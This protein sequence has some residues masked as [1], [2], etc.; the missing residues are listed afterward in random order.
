MSTFTFTVSPARETQAV[1]QDREFKMVWHQEEV[2]G[3][4]AAVEALRRLLPRLKSFDCI[5]VQL[6]GGAKLMVF[7][8]PWVGTNYVLC[9]KLSVSD[10]S[11]LLSEGERLG[12]RQFGNTASGHGSG[13]IS[14]CSSEQDCG[15]ARKC[16]QLL[17]VLADQSSRIVVEGVSSTVRF[18]P[19]GVERMIDPQQPGA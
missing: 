9:G 16:Q 1:N 10:V 4:N 6:A 3:L 5:R 19:D 12:L 2:T 8:R 11:Q 7:E 18:F 15:V 17:G 14:F 13:G